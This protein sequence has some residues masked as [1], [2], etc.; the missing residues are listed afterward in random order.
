MCNFV[1]EGDVRPFECTCVW[2][3][4]VIQPL[5]RARYGKPSVSSYWLLLTTK[6]V[7]AT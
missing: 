5:R 3:L 1:I 4:K 6:P 2:R 7:I